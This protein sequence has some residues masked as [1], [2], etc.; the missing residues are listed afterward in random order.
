MYTKIGGVDILVGGAYIRLFRSGK[1]HNPP[2][3]TFCESQNPAD[4]S[5][6]NHPTVHLT[7]LSYESDPKLVAETQDFTSFHPHNYH[8]S[9]Y[10][11]A[12]IA[13]IVVLR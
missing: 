9:A 12:D 2:T 6:S 11:Y 13:D 1:S 3:L 4:R 5:I 10:A 7:M 8:V